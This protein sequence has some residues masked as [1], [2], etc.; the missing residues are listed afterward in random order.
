MTKISVNHIFVM[1]ILSTNILKDNVIGIFRMK[2]YDLPILLKNAIS[3][4]MSLSAFLKLLKWGYN[5]DFLI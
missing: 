4:V 2:K 5:G 3:I 1:Q